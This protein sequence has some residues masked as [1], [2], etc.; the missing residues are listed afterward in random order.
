M[1]LVLDE[2]VQEL[3]SSTCGVQ[4]E[5]EASSSRRE[6]TKKRSK[7]PRQPQQ[8]TKQ[9][10][11]PL[12]FRTDSKP[13]KEEEENDND[14]NEYVVEKIVK[15]QPNPQDQRNRHFEIRLLGEPSSRNMMHICL[16]T[17]A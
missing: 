3:L 8:Q 17:S 13:E 7:K 9:R 6:Q 14:E 5:A 2:V 15:W 10:K 16:H 12:V 4:E 1:E 11:A